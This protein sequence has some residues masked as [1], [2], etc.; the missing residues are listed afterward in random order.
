MKLCKKNG[1]EEVSNEV[2]VTERERGLTLRL[3]LVRRDGPYEVLGRHVDLSVTMLTY[4]LQR[5]KVAENLVWSG[6]S[7]YPVLILHH[8]PARNETTI[9]DTN[10]HTLGMNITLTYQIINQ[11]KDPAIFQFCVL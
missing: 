6:V 1:S 11:I 7:S 4:N 2:K 3:F 9:I 8:L 10:F 5:G